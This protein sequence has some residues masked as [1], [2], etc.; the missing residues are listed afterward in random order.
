MTG[1]RGRG[2]KQLIHDRKKK[3]GYWKSTAEALDRPVWEIGFGI[4]CGTVVR[5]N[6]E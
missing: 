4:G 2:S 5:Q 1:R 3:R 6:E